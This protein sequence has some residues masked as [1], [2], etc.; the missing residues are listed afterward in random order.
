MSDT[1]AHG[2]VSCDATACVA[3]A[4]CMCP[5]YAD[6]PPRAATARAACASANTSVPSAKPGR[7]AIDIDIYGME[8]VPEWFLLGKD[9]PDDGAAAPAAKRT[10]VGEGAESG[11]APPPPLPPAPPGTFNGGAMGAA[12]GGAAAGAVGTP[13]AMGVGMG[14]GQGTAMPDPIVFNQ[15][16]SARVMELQRM[17]M[18]RGQPIPAQVAYNMATHEV[19]ASLGMAMPMTPGGMGAPGMMGMAGLG[20]AHAGMPPAGGGVPAGG[21]PPGVPQG[22]PPGVPHGMPPTIDSGSGALGAGGAAGGTS[23]GPASGAAAGAGAGAGAAVAVAEPAPKHAVAPGGGVLV[24]AAGDGLSMVSANALTVAPT[25]R[26][27]ASR[28]SPSSASDVLPACSGDNRPH[29][30]TAATMSQEELRAALP[31]YKYDEAKMKAQLDKIESS[32]EAKLSMILHD[33]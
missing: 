24:F 23:S 16:V 22:M 7:D 10:R 17:G 14:Y 25:L 30:Y 4:P 21:V 11:A 32:L 5:R 19:S 1:R 2:H 15:M 12:P 33:K 29:A 18:M 3:A 20:I 28:L 8:N 6:A 26:L 13:G 9:E 27:H 31:K